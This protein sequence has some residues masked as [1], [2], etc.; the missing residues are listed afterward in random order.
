MSKFKFKMQ[1]VLEI[2]EKI[3][4]QKENEHTKAINILN[5]Y[6]KQKVEVVNQKRKIVQDLKQGI[7]NN[8]S[9]KEIASYNNYINYMKKVIKMI[10]KNIKLSQ[11]DVDRKREQLEDAIKERKVMGKL[12]EKEFEKYKEQEKRLEQNLL[13]EIASYKYMKK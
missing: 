13:D 4:K 11:T 12:K 7:I 6:K 8:I 2:K 9:S 1:K 10:E 3:E 5:K